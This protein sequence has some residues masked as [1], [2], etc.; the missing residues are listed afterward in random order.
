MFVDSGRAVAFS[1]RLSKNLQKI[2]RASTLVYASEVTN[3]GGE[4]NSRTGKFRCPV[5]GVYQFFVSILSRKEERVKTELVVNGR[6]NLL[7]YSSGD[8]IHRGSLGM[9]GVILQLE[10]GDLV[11]VRVYH[12]FGDYIHCCWSTFSGALIKTM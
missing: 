9:N 10:E 2:G 8:E 1:A 6:R 4:Y 12:G 7:L 5:D 11:W 3:I